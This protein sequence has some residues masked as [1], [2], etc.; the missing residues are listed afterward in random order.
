MLSTQNMEML[1]ILEEFE[2]NANAN[3]TGCEHKYNADDSRMKG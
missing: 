3:F 1:E 2:S